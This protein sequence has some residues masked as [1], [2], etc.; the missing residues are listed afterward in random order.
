MSPCKV[1]TDREV[2]ATFF[3][4]LQRCGNAQWTHKNI[5]TVSRTAHPYRHSGSSAYVPAILF[6]RWAPGH[7]WRLL[8]PQ[9]EAW[10]PPTLDQGWWAMT[11]ERHFAGNPGKEMCYLPF[12]A[13][14]TPVYHVYLSNSLLSYQW[15]YLVRANHISYLILSHPSSLYLSIPIL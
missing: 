2:D 7:S 14:S 12:A 4:K 8:C 6:A 1:T 5:Y 11:A 9:V 15:S 3:S 10:L 13:P